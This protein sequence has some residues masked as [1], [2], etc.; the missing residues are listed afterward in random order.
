MQVLGV[1][2]RCA[3]VLCGHWCVGRG[4]R[5]FEGSD[6]FLAVSRLL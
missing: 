3:E 2:A 5:P 4:D 1:W 6:V